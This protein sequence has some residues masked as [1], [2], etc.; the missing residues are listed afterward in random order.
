M[1]TQTTPLSL[2]LFFCFLI[3][4]TSRTHLAKAQQQE[5]RSSV[6]EATQAGQNEKALEATWKL[7]EMDG[8]AVDD[9]FPHNHPTIEF[10]VKENQVAGFA[11]CNQFHGQLTLD[12]AYMKI[13]GVVATKKA[14]PALDE[15]EEFL[16]ILQEID[17]YDVTG[18]E[19]SLWSGG[20]LLLTFRKAE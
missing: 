11:G 18:N 1:K 3:F 12:G 14:C 5:K 7:A 16:A 13:V 4:G 15:E 10:N 9:L 8:E 19:L 17:Q 6:P 20:Q 2:I